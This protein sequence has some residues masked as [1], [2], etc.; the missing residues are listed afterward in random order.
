MD[1]LRVRNGSGE[2]S[3]AA[4]GRPSFGYA[5]RMNFTVYSAPGSSPDDGPDTYDGDSN[6]S[7]QDGS[8]V[9]EVATDGAKVIYGPAGWLRLVVAPGQSQ[10]FYAT[11]R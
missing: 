10:P 11:G 9:L 6:F 2:P 4:F 7:I 5:P 1:P 8:G 3:T